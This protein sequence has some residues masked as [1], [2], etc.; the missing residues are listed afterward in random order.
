[1]SGHPADLQSLQSR[2]ESI[3][4]E[5]ATQDSDDL[6][7]QAEKLSKTLADALRVRNGPIDNHTALGNTALP[8]TISSLLELAIDKTDRRAVPSPGRVNV[9]IE[10]LRLGANLC[11]DHDE[12][13]THLLEVGFPQDIVSILEG[14]LE[15]LPTIPL[16]EPAKFGVP[17][18]RIMR[19]A[20]GVLLNASVGHDGVKSRLNS[21]EA[22][23]TIL[24]LSTAIYPP[25]SWI[26]CAHVAASGTTPFAE[27]EW[28]LRSTLSNWAWRA[29]TELKEVP[30]DLQIFNTDVLPLLAPPL[31]A[32]TPPFAPTPNLPSDLPIYNTLIQADFDALEESCTLIE[33][34]SLD[35]EEVRH[36]LAKGW[37]DPGEHRGVPCFSIILDFVEH[38]MYPPIWSYI[39]ESRRQANEKVLGMCKGA[40]IK[41]VVEVA[42]ED[43]SDELLWDWNVQDKAQNGFISRLVGWIT[44]YVEDLERPAGSPPASDSPNRDDLVICASLS[45]GNIARKDKIAKALLSPPLSLAPVLTSKYLIGRDTDIKIRHAVMGLL[46]HLAQPS[47]GSTTVRIALTQVDVVQRIVLSGIWDEAEDLMVNVVQ[48]SAI[49]VV[50]NLC[51]NSLEHTFALVLPPKGS[52]PNAPTGL[53]TLLQL[54]ER[55]DS[56]PIKSEGTR[57]LVNVVKTLWSCDVGTKDSDKAAEIQAQRRLAMNAVLTSECA[58][59]LSQLVSRSAKYPILI[60]EGVLAMSFFST[61]KTGASLVISAITAPAPESH[62]QLQA[63][64]SSTDANAS[65]TPTPWCTLDQIAVALDTSDDPGKYPVEIRMNICS[66]L[67]QLEKNAPKEQ[68]SRT[69][70]MLQPV[71]EETVEN[72]QGQKLDNKQEMLLTTAKKL[73]GQW[74]G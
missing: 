68:L 44:S 22:A 50:K 6:W 16:G 13:R 58:A 71:V 20:I 52:P 66:F 64:E 67:L 24:K 73:L 40:L 8:Q 62:P 59:A 46:K 56:F 30:D 7:S 4:K 15:G 14:Y 45:L 19:T 54:I 25:G 29:I 74:S 12:N 61:N 1:M 41:A 48:L 69:K 3:G 72:L 60:N 11:M 43:N 35:V 17:D 36:S 55:S 21:L 18:L 34:L 70:A 2:L 63:S 53:Q 10:L 49:G 27:E 65:Q 33:S 28:N 37:R 23:L 57:I 42:G 32:F 5:L 47:K 26:P 38:G 31:R 9:V 51:N 39:S